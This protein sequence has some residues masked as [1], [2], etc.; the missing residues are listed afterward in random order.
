M[1]LVIFVAGVGSAF[2]GYFISQAYR[3]SSASIIAP[4]E[5]FTLVLAVFWGYFIWEEIPDLMST[6]GIIFI[7][8]SG[9]FVAI[10]E[11]HFQIVPTAKRLS[12]RR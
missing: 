6:I 10:R 5:Y 3:Y 12:G 1:A 8:S 4:F 2:G 11:H 9:V 7:I